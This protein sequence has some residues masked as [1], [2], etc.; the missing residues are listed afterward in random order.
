MYA[1][2][3]AMYVQII[4]HV[5]SYM[6]IRNQNLSNFDVNIFSISFMLLVII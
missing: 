4:K 3:E 1:Y 2:T 6:Y 5:G